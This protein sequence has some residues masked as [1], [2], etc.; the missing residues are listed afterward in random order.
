MSLRTAV[1]EHATKTIFFLGIGGAGMRALAALLHA[2]GHQITGTDFDYRS[3]QEDAAFSGYVTAPEA[4]ATSLVTQADVLI[5]SDAVPDTH[6][7]RQLAAAHRIPQQ[8][9][10]EA[11]RDF[12]RAFTTVAVTGTHGKS[13]TTAL[14]A[15]ILVAAGLDP[16]V[17]V[18]AAVPGW[19]QGNARVGHGK[20][21]VVEADEY[22]RH[23][24]VLQPTHAIVTTIDFDH[25][26]YFH[27]VA[28]VEAAY[29]DFLK[30][31]PS[32]G[33]VVTPDTVRTTY[34]RLPWPRHTHT[35]TAAY[36]GALPLPGRH[37][38]LNAALAVAMTE[39][40]GVPS[41][42]ATQAL[43]SFPGLAR[44]FETIGAI[45]NMRI[46]SDY[47][48]HPTEIAATL[49]AAT[50][51]F[52]GKKIAAVIEPHTTERVTTFL[53]DFVAALTA[54][55]IAQIIIYPTFYVKGREDAGTALASS[56]RLYEAVAAVHSN[57]WHVKSNN[58]LDA[59][60]IKIAADYDIAIAFT[61]G[62]LDT[63][64]RSQYMR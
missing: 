55:P 12:A 17:Q 31:I 30:K 4:A 6:P 45:G 8:M 53:S 26:D 43:A 57:V 15:H 50:E 33:W 37:M 7:L 40:L 46:I 61:A 54:I 24:L 16:T 10:F 47:G 35:V 9:L 29:A 34:P 14:L 20:Y 23:F 41:A 52:P 21:F 42:T 56:Q 64:L 25:P 27:S 60:L 22:R 11:V 48:H 51:T 63:F 5:Y 1:K 2:R 38:Q 13:S 44:R 36:Q 18:G 59:R 62:S 58:E 19:E 28:D 49:A 3:L 32:S 39:K